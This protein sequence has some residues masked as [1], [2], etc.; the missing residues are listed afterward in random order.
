[1]CRQRENSI[2]ALQVRRALRAFSAHVRTDYTLVNL[3]RRLILRAQR[4]F[5]KH[6]LRALDALQLSCAVESRL[7][8]RTSIMFVS[9]D[10]KLLNVASAEGF[11]VDNPLL[12]P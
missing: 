11:Q 5:I 9:A 12:H 3:D 1:M 4:L 8:L 6:P 7:S 10:T 2:T